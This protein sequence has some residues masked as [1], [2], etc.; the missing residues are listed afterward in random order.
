VSCDQKNYAIMSSSNSHPNGDTETIGGIVQSHAYSILSA[1]EVDYEGGPFRILRMRNP[2]RTGEWEGE[3][4]DKS[5][6]WSDD[7]K[8]QLGHED[9]DDGVFFIPYRDFWTRFDMTEFAMLLQEPVPK[10]QLRMD[11]SSKEYFKITL[12]GDYD[13]K[14]NVFGINVQQ[15]GERFSTF[16]R[17]QNPYRASDVNIKLYSLTGETPELVKSETEYTTNSFMKSMICRERTLAAGEYLLEVVI[18]WNAEAEQQRE[19]KDAV[20]DLICKDDAGFEML[21]KQESLELLKNIE[22]QG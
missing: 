19:H 16:K 18:N 7:L 2:W 3:F 9:K 6:C 4:S 10:K 12:D 11:Q 14:N 5:D 21:S 13:T 15:Q 22:F 1:H 20:V 17:D 8:A